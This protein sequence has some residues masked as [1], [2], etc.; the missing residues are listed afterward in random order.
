[1][2]GSP[3]SS[4]TGAEDTASFP[5]S[6]QGS[7][8]VLRAIS[9][10][11]VGGTAIHTILL[12]E[13]MRGS[14]YKVHL[15]CGRED[16]GE[17]N[18]LDLA[19]KRGIV[20]TIIPELG[21]RIHPWRDMVALWKLYRLMRRERPHIVD[22]HAAKAGTLGRLAARLAGVPIVIHTFHGHVLE[23]YF[24]TIGSWWFRTVERW[25]ARRTDRIVMVSRQ[26]RGEL[27]SLGIVPPEKITYLPLGLEL[28]SFAEYSD[29][30]PTFKEEL[31]LGQEDHLVGTVAR[32]VPIKGVEDFLRAAA[33]IVETR[34]DTWFAIIGDGRLRPHL[35]EEAKKLG[36]EGRVFFTGFR[37][38]LPRVYA[39]L[40]VVVLSSYNE[41]LPVT[42]IES[43]AC[44]K[45]VVATD[46]GGVAELVEDETTGF[47]VPER[48]P[49][50]LAERVDFLL[51][52]PDL[53]ARMGRAGSERVFRLYSKERLV[54]DTIYLYDRLLEEKGLVK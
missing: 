22:T 26:G 32:L 21:R 34:S 31:G 46:V 1:M 4:I 24:G 17:G 15:V 3:S 29:P 19:E 30:Q 20:P 38:D 47:L 10:L 16:P 48:E 18:M 36:L 6:D 14:R 37:R 8:R 49:G 2:T 5:G 11:N 40:D 44:G 28:E 51:S 13:G 12:T 41:G 52:R 25:L 33:D 23:K 43:M 45:P 7:I 42:I 9:R 35:E 27:I 50:V 54:K 53:L 39:S